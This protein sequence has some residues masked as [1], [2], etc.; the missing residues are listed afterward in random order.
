MTYKLASLIKVVGEMR[1]NRR[2][3]S[4]AFGPAL[5]ACARAPQP[6]R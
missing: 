6:G 2:F 1:P 5:R 3:E 4:D